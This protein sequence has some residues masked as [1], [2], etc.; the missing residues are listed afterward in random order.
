MAVVSEDKMAASI[1]ESIMARLRE[2]HPMQRAGVA[3]VRLWT[4]EEF[5][6]KESEWQDL[7]ARSDAD[8]LFMSWVWQSCWWRAHARRLNAQLAI[9][10]AYS[11]DHR[12]VGL[13]PFYVRKFTYRSLLRGTRVELLGSTFRDS[14]GT[15]SEYL[16]FIV[17]RQYVAAFLSALQG[18]LCSDG[19]WMDLVIA[20][21]AQNSVA[22][23]FARERLTQCAYLRETDRLSAHITHFPRRFEDY[24]KALHPTVRRKLW[25]HRSKLS[26]PVLRVVEANEVAQFLTQLTAYHH[27]RW[28]VNNHE[29]LRNDFYCDVATRLAER[30]L[31]H[32]TYL[33][34]GGQPISAMFNVR[35]GGME[36]NIQSGFSPNAVPHASPGYLHFGFALEDAFAS[37]IER[38]NFLAGAGRNRDYK[39]DFLTTEEELAT[40]QSVRGRALAWL[41]RSYDRRFLSMVGGCA[42]CLGALLDTPAN[43][44]GAF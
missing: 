20:N 37:G 11:A 21:A 38:F 34:S 28:G 2:V 15:F 25:N 3:A 19:K 12:L 36:Y 39:H 14:T 29:H 1:D 7:L 43:G 33:L 26:S 41:Y 35:V 13:A 31:L 24:L 22:A 27:H 40:F 10:A 18:A 42:P 6:A 17:D 30:G 32:M 5:L 16:D 44:L 23:R 4:E 9:Y 8:P